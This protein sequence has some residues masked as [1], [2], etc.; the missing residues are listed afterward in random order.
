MKSKNF[1]KVSFKGLPFS[2][3]IVLGIPV[4]SS[5]SFDNSFF[6]LIYSKNLWNSSCFCIYYYIIFHYLFSFFYISNS[7]LSS[8][9]TTFL[10]TVFA[11][12]LFSVCIG[13]TFFGF[14]YFST[15]FLASSSPCPDV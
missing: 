3:N 8:N 12:S 13:I 11:C 14:V 5:I 6:G 1:S 4:K 15:S 2:F 10:N 7:S 9:I